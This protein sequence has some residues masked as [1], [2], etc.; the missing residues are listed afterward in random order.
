MCG[1]P[2]THC[3]E[4]CP[5][6]CAHT[7]CSAKCGK[8]CTVDPCTEPCPKMLPCRHPCVGFCGDPCPPLCRVCNREELEEILFGFEQDEDARYVLLVECGHVIESQGME[9]WLKQT[10]EGGIDFFVIL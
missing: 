3:T 5:R 10:R 1:Q 6:A 9:M 2:C 4:R 8:T 7:R